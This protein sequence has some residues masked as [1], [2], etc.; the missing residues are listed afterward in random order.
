MR[1]LT[2]AALLVLGACGQEAAPAST[3]TTATAAAQSV[4]S[5]AAAANNCPAQA[6]FQW[7]TGSASY[8]IHATASG[9]DCASA[10]ATITIST[11]SGAVVHN[12][13]VQASDV[14]GLAEATSVA[15]MQR[16]LGEWITPAGASKDSTGDLAA[17]APGATEPVDAE[18]PFHP[19]AGITREAYE[20][21]RRADAPMYCYEQSRE[22][23]LCLAMR[24]GRLSVLGVQTFAG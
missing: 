7:S 3:S 6:E 22:G 9:A 24:D 23:A 13:T 1:S 14:Q 21:L 4:T 12:A 16:M 20:A 19:A 5:T 11:G 17:W 15:D 8:A 2:I 10:Q 18:V